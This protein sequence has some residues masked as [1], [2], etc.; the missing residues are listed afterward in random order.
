MRA[1]WPKA[2]SLN[3]A[4]QLLDLQRLYPQG[5]GRLVKGRLIWRCDLRPSAFSREYFAEIDY[6][7]GRF[8]TT[9]ILKP[10][11]RELAGGCKPPHVY[12]DPGDP[13]C[14]FYAAARE[15]NSSM[16]IARTIVPWTCEWL[17][18]F[19]AWLF[20]GEWDGGGISHEPGGQSENDGRRHIVNSKPS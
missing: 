18:H 5:A 14:L 15:W 6:R 12:A 13:L 10:V 20:T 1:R 16:L 4:H 9:R 19:E 7:L 3:V 11:P 17:F 8:P 2:Q